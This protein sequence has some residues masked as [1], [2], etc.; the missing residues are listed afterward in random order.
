YKVK[1]A[2]SSKKE[3]PEKIF[4]SNNH[5]CAEF[6]SAL[7]DCDGHVCENRNE[8]QYDTKSE[9]LA[10]QITNLLRTRFKIESQIKEEYKRAT[11]GKKEKQKY[12]TTK[13]NFITY[14]SKTKC[15]KAWW[16]ELKEDIG[17]TY[18]TLNKRLKNGWSI[19]R[20]F[21]EPKHKE[22]DRYA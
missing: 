9:K 6:I 5:I 8:I 3:I 4:S 13:S 14:K 22:F 7:F 15:L 19:D 10:F 11:N 17:I 16:I 2:T 21:T 12:N 1:P 20:A 18:S